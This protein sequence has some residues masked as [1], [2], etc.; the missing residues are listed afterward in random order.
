[1]DETN[2]GLHRLDNIRLIATDL[3]GTLL[4][5]SLQL[6]FSFFS[7]LSDLK[8]K[9]IHFA[10]ASGRNWTSQKG[11]F[12][13]HLNELFFICDNGAY[14]VEQNKPIFISRL[15]RS[16]WT[17][18]AHR[19]LPYEKNCRAIFCGIKGTYVANYKHSPELSAL[20]EHYYKDLAIVQ[21]PED[22][23]DD[24]FKISV[25]C[26]T[27]TGG[28]F[29][30]EFFSAYH[31]QANVMRTAECFLDIM[32]RGISK[33]TGLAF[34]QRKLHISPEET[35]VFGDFENDIGLFEHAEYSFLMEN[36]PIS[37]RKHARYLAP[38]N[39]DEGVTEIIKR[40]IL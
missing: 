23:H 18:V 34:L 14:L 19:C 33:G 30:D 7:V 29:F 38:S 39:E 2:K 11:F 22:I 20:I 35:A 9:G 40:Y 3:D 26:L 1:M 15:P 5:S 27:G 36:A 32:N 24:I 13:G 28:E 37:M 31:I 25:C 12:S 4:N 17:D 16:L 6:P 10:A 8:K 21:T